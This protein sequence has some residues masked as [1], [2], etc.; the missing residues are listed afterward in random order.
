M[1]NLYRLMFLLAVVVATSA[2]AWGRENDSL[3][4]RVINSKGEPIGY[5]TVVA[6]QNNNQVAG[7]TT[8]EKG[9]FVMTLAAGEYR[10]VVDFVGYKSIDR[11]IKVAG[12]T[13]LGTLTMQEEATEIGEVVVKAQMI[14]READRF[15]V[16]VANSDSAIGKDGEELLRQSPGV[17][18]QD[19]NISVN[20]ASGTKLYVNEREMKLTG[21][22]LLNY[23]RSLKAE[24][25]AKIEIV[26]QTGADHDAN[27][28]GG[29]IKITLRRRLEN[30]VMGTVGIY[31][32]LG[33]YGHDPYPYARIN[34]NVGKFTLSGAV[35][36][37]NS[38]HVF[39]ADEQTD[40]LS[41]SSRMTSSTDDE[42]RSNEFATN[43]SVVYQAN[44]KHSIGFDYSWFNNKENDYIVSST[45]FDTPTDT[46]L[47]NSI[48]DGNSDR[49][50]HYAT[51]NYIFKTD[52]LGSMFKVLADYHSRD[53]L[54]THANSTTINAGGGDIDSLYNDRTKTFFRVATASVARER[55]FSQE[56]QLKYGAKYTYN[57]INSAAQYRYLLGQEWVPSVVSDHGIS[58]TE[59]I[60]A[61]Y[62]IASFRKGRW[63]AVMGLR[64][65][66]TKALGKGSDVSQEYFSLFP[67]ANLSYALDKQGKYSLVAQYSRSISRP[68]FW[69]L[70]PTRT[71][72]SDYTYQTGNALLDP[73]YNNRISLTGVVAYKY[74]ITLAAA[75]QTDAIQQ[76]V[77]A[78]EN[79]PRMLNLT[80]VNLPKLNNYT[81]SIY[82]PFAVTKWWDWNINLT[83][84]LAEQQLTLGAPIEFNK[85]AQVT[86]NMT[87]KLPKNFFVDLGY[88][89]MTRVKVSNAIVNP[90]H[91]LSVSLKKRV[92]DS[93]TFVCEAVNVIAP[94]Q[95]LDFVQD[96]FTRNIITDG[97]GSRF[98][99]RLGATWSFK[100]GKAFNAKQVE[101]ASDESR[102]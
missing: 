68:S 58:Y 42:M 24:D 25:I 55:V 31:S 73:S 19:D 22:D 45:R 62:A 28:S 76:M 97:Y 81:A 30:G 80:Y 49:T 12:V 29:A 95:D 11:T 74:S 64:G 43:F 6:M 101:K 39:L 48:Y 67:N 14:R 87:F 18:I 89:G 91:N 32:G 36:Y 86:S 100:S 33:K 82:L 78:D 53:G 50:T 72:I 46:R 26:P 38:K 47:S 93:W 52:S 94:V 88:W 57:E 8:D 102:M 65:E 69:N 20:G 63:S 84:I 96:D 99:I 92:K 2:T 34:A 44:P 77:V 41:T 10:L 7:T 9:I 54:D 56:W 98:R 27:S 79:D 3:K 15:V 75:I 71:Q 83:G 51:F 61:A 59:N 37:Y 4:G 16:D 23:I 40:Y 17:W 35:T 1:K 66:Y 13:D 5:A 90:G 85:Y 70:T 60:S 21:A